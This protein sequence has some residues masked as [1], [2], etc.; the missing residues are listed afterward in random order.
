MRTRVSNW[1]YRIATS[2]LVLATSAYVRLMWKVASDMVQRYPAVGHGY[3]SALLPM[4]GTLT[5]VLAAA[6]LLLRSGAVMW[7]FPLFWVQ[8]AMP[9]AVELYQDGTPVGLIIAVSS[10]FGPLIVVMPLFYWLV[11]RQELRMP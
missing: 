2:A 4:L 6:A 7:L 1:V 11:R 3:F 9:F 8:H 5:L 10:V